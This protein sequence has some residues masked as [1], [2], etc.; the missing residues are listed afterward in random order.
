MVPADRHCANRGGCHHGIVRRFLPRLVSLL[1]PG[2]F[3]WIPARGAPP[4]PG[5]NFT[6]PDCAVTM[7]WIAPGSF[8][9]SDPQ[10]ANDDTEVTLTQGYWLGRTE[11]TQAQWQTVI[12]HHPWFKNSPL[13]SYFKGA[14]RPVEQVSW[15]M[16]MEFC[17]WFN[18]LERAAGRLP[19]GYAYTLPTEAQ[20]EYAARAGTTGK[21]PGDL[22]AI[23]WYDANSGGVTHPVAQKQPN[24]WGLYDMIGNVQEWC[25]DWYAA[26]PGGRARDPT[27]PAF[28]GHRSIR[29]GSFLAT[30]GWCRVA[31]RT[32]WPNY[33]KTR[34]LGFRLALAPT[35]MSAAVPV[36]RNGE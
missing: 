31:Q 35:D 2:L 14:D 6:L 12:A 34:G 17:A 3:I 24:A 29:G 27:G 13:P 26:Y 19:A 25:W 1:I 9:M 11:V 18:E 22:D 8:L 16:V 10:G 30:A 20:W 32:R 23:A 5:A 7:V 28:G 21:Y 4:E 15:D 33:L 36:G